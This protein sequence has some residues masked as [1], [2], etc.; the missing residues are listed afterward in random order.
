MGKFIVPNIFIAGTKA[1]AQEVNENFVSIQEEL[2][3]KALKEGSQTQTFYVANATEDG[4]AVSKNQMQNFVNETNNSTLAKIGV[5]KLSLFANSGNTDEEGNAE[6][7]TFSD[8]EL[9]FL[10][11]NNYPSLKGNL[12]GENIEITE[13]ENF[14]LSGFANGKY[15]IFVNKNGE[16]SVL[17]N[18]IYIQPKQPSLILNDVWV[19]TSSVPDKI[20]QFDGSNKINFDKLLIG[21]VTIENSQITSVTTIPYDSK[22]VTIVNQS[23]NAHIIETYQ[24]EHSWYRIWSDGF[25]E[26]GGIISNMGVNSYRDI[27][28][29]KTYKDMNF[30]VIAS[31]RTVYTGSWGN[32]MGV[33][34]ISNSQFRVA[35]GWYGDSIAVD[36]QW[37]TCGYT[38]F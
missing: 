30:S 21:K 3:K 28:L 2:E 10:V 20:T 25:V 1:K 5:D 33:V 35:Q 27:T 38:E 11:G 23:H 9:T 24:N 6:L 14:S 8:L 31:F 7:I 22:T 4:Q 18:N 17:S 12:L 32:T 13:I 16:I 36:I 26:Q 19:D 15:N 34:P 37:R 29:L